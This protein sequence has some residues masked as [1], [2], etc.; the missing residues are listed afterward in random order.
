MDVD[1]VP[2]SDFAVF[3]AAYSGLKLLLI[4]IA[5]EQMIA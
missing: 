2:V 5:Q 1:E 4:E 3:A